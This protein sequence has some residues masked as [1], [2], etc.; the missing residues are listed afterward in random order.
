MP[1]EDGPATPREDSPATPRADGPAISPARRLARLPALGPGVVAAWRARIAWRHLAQQ[2]R[3]LWRWWRDSREV[4]NFTYDLTPR[5]LEQLAAFLCAASGAEL[6]RV[7]GLMRELDADEALHA[8]LRRAT[9]ASPDA[10]H[11][12][13]SPR[14]GR[15]IGWYV[16]VRLFRPRLV[17]ETGVD[18]GLGACVLS[19]A[20]LRNAAEGAPGRYVGIDHNP[21]AGWLL[22]EPWSRVGSVVHGDSHAELAK[23]ACID[24]LI[25][26]SDHDPA[27]EAA[28]YELALPRL[29][30]GALVLSDNAHAS[31]ALWRFA[32]QTKR[33]YL[34][35]AEQPRDHWYPGAGIGLALPGV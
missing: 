14:F 22:A 27:H 26:D 7:L 28:E 10:A 1:L 32:R 23:L 5:N 21:Q 19:A 15:R 6:E 20:L 11:S 34:Y 16:L 30:D 8:H 17:V 13:A 29:S 24:L 12:D 31:D 18:K 9:L 3:L 4:T 33:R 25:H 2:T 35:F